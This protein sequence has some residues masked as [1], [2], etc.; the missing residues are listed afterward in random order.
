MHL[1]VALG[2]RRRWLRI[3]EPVGAG[4]GDAEGVLAGARIRDIAGVRSEAV[5]GL[6]V[7]LRVTGE[8]R[9]VARERE[10]V[11]PARAVDLEGRGVVLVFEGAILRRLLRNEPEG[12]RI[13]D[14]A[15]ATDLPSGLGRQVRARD[16]A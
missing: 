8:G 6:A 15:A 12:H 14:A 1:D 13:A 4:H 10:R 9:A 16:G 2:D 11:D 7:D 3:A 5:A